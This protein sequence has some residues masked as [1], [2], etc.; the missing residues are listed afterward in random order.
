MPYVH[1]IELIPRTKD[2][3]IVELETALCALLKHDDER[4]GWEGE[5]SD[6]EKRCLAVLLNTLVPT[7]DDDEADETHCCACG[8]RIDT[9]AQ[10]VLDGAK[11]HE[12][13]F[14][15][16]TERTPMTDTTQSPTKLPPGK[17]RPCEHVWEYTGGPDHA[18]HF[19]CSRCEA[20]MV[21]PVK[22]QASR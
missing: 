12:Q 4:F 13:C 5:P 19:L 11:Y 17:R 9:Q 20:E 16:A 21:A 8:K 18:A 6:I 3:R 14:I 22:Q 2:E 10:W 1:Q 7:V 15:L